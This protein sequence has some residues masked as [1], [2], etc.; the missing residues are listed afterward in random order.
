M[1]KMTKLELEKVI[2]PDKYIFIAKGMRGVISC[3]NKRYNKA[4][5]EYYD[6]EKPKTYI[7]YLDMNN[8]H[9]HAM[10]QHLSYASFKMVN[11]INEI[12]QKLTKIKNNSLTRYI[13]EIDLEYPKNIHYEHSDNPLAPENISIQKEW[14]SDYSIEIVNEHNITVESIKKLTPNLMNKNNYVIHGRNLHQCLE[15]RLIFKKVHRILKYK[16]KDWMKPYIDFNTHKRQEVTNDAD[17]NLFKLL[18]NAVYGKTMENLRK[19]SK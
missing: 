6:S 14:L 1:L 9:G 12:E 16:Q 7:T 5:N 17:K 11:N 2:D 3:F 8:L 18:N 10:S 19:K 4:N 13:L 15:K